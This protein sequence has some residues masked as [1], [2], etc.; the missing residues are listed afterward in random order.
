MK[1]ASFNVQE[2]ATWGVIEGEEVY[3]VGSILS[4]RFP[5]VKS[6]IAK[7]AL[8]EVQLQMANAPR[9]GFNKVTWLP[10]I[11]NP[12]KIF[13]VGLNYET[14][15]KETGRAEVVHLDHRPSRFSSARALVYSM[16]CCGQAVRAAFN[17]FA[18]AA[19]SRRS[20][21]HSPI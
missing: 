15:R 20:K 16:T 5:D 10:V 4:P 19:S 13:C 1:L 8:G 12:E 7:G 21:C 3:D 2:K 9:L 6:V 17:E 14:H 11:P 18:A